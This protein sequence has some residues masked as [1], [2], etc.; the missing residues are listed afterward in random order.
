MSTV[1]VY[2]KIAILRV[3]ACVV[4]AAWVTLAFWAGAIGLHRFKPGSVGIAA[5]LVP[6]LLLVPLA[7][8]HILLSLCHRCPICDKSPTAQGLGRTHGDWSAVIIATLLGK[9]FSCVHCGTRHAT[10]RNHT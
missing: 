6:I 2:P 3:D 10:S 5:L 9:H 1:F 7:V 8:S 4:A